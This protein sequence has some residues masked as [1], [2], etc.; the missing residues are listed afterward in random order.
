MSESSGPIYNVPLIDWLP[1]GD[2][3]MR[4]AMPTRDDLEKVAKI[5]TRTAAGYEVLLGKH[6]NLVD[7]MGRFVAYVDEFPEECILPTMAKHVAVMKAA[8]V[9]SGGEA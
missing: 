5:S 4:Q 2:S 7:I 9:A 8:I 1:L 6:E 3:G